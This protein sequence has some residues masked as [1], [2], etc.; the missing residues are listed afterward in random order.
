MEARGLWLLPIIK[1]NTFPLEL[2]KQELFFWHEEVGEIFFF[3]TELGKGMKIQKT[4]MHM[5]KE[6][7]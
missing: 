2:I 5:W 1:Q 4:T 7:R 6:T 3:F